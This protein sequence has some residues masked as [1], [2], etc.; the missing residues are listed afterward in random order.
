MLN[1]LF[2]KT[3]ENQS[4][5]VFFAS[6]IGGIDAWNLS[7]FLLFNTLTANSQCCRGSDMTQ[8]DGYLLFSFNT[9]YYNNK[10]LGYMV[11]MGIHQPKIFSTAKWAISS[12]RILWY[13]EWLVLFQNNLIFSWVVN[14]RKVVFFWGGG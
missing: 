7:H 3:T 1:F 6:E 5:C 12:K 14:M 8:G 11:H 4:K 9:L 13:F 10:V 2:T